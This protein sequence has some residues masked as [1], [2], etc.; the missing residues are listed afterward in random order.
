MTGVVVSTSRFTGKERDSES[1][2]D[3]FGARYYASSMGRM[4]SPDPSGAAFSDPSSPQSWNMYSYVQNNPLNAVDPDGLDCVYID[5]DSGQLTGFN[6]GDC[7]NSTTA[8]GRWPGHPP[9]NPPE[10][11]RAVPCSSRSLR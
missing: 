4:L 10:L 11:R 5:N 6:R 1:G 8:S 3:Y 7:D 2:N 9:K